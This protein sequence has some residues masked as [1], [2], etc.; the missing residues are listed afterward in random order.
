MFIGQYQHTIDA[1]GRLSIPRRFREI[2]QGTPEQ[3]LVVTIAE[4]PYLVVY[5]EREWQAICQ[6]V[7]ERKMA[8]DADH[9][10]DEDFLRDFYAK[11][12]ECDLDSQGRL[13]LTQKLRDHAG[14]NGEAIVVGINYKFEIWGREQW[15]D[16]Q[17]VAHRNI[18]K[19]RRMRLA[20]GM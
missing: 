15:Q 12:S 5:P 19:I 8:E 7:Q 6:R 3:A 16:R 17:A 20:V 18:D 11:A 4:D 13:L 1:K 9:Y 14:L 2:I 10:I